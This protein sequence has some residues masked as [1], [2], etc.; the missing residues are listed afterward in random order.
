[1]AN[2]ES[3][4]RQCRNELTKLARATLEKTTS[5]P[6]PVQTL[7]KRQ[8]DLILKQFQQ[9]AEQA[10]SNQ[11]EHL[12]AMEKHKLGMFQGLLDPPQLGVAELEPLIAGILEVFDEGI[13]D[14]NGL[15]RDDHTPS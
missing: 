12:Y 3:A 11:L 4:R 9:L 13:E 14:Y 2:I 10:D 6:E 8:V 15:I 1:M 5:R 7:F